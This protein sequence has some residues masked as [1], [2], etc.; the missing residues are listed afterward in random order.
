[1]SIKL[2]STDL[3]KAYVGSNLVDKIYAGENIIHLGSHHLELKPAKTQ[4]NLSITNFSTT[5]TAGYREVNVVAN[6]VRSIDQIFTLLHFD[7]KHFD[8]GTYL[9]TFDVTQNSG[10][11]INSS[12]PFSSRNRVEIVTRDNDEIQDTPDSLNKDR[13]AVSEG[14]NSIISTVFND[15]SSP[16]APSIALFF[17]RK[18]IFDI[19]IS[20]IQLKYYSN[21]L[22]RKN[23]VIH[24]D[25]ENPDSYSGSGTTITD[26]QG[27]ANATLTN[28][29][30]NSTTPKNWEIDEHHG[31]HTSFITFGDVETFN[32]PQDFTF[33]IWFEFTSLVGDNDIIT[34][35]GHVTNEP[36]LVWYDAAVHPTL[37]AFGGGNTKTISF[38]VTDADGTGQH[39]IAGP[40]DIIVANQV[41]HLVV[42]KE[43]STGRSRIWLNG[44]KQADHTQSSTDGMG[45]NTDPLKLGAATSTT[46]TADSDMKIYAFQAY[47]SFLTDTQIDQLWN[48]LKDRFGL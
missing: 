34:K 29:V 22:V 9:I 33:S 5:W 28:G 44:V 15:G 35:G 46:S 17:H 26:L 7:S 14:S 43:A 41:Y 45:N 40:S 23:L 11:S 4:S 18:A 10:T 13:F 12:I 20:N 3:S 32:A 47:D 2:G 21:E 27:T 31:N 6:G 39:W 38:M 37:P 36:I 42:Q 19:T 24:I 48:Y 25:A 16:L 1:M 8:L 30:F